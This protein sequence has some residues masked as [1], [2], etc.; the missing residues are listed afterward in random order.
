[1]NANWR[2]P[3]LTATKSLRVLPDLLSA[4][5]PS[6]SPFLIVQRQWQRFCSGCWTVRV[7]LG[8]RGPQPAPRK[9]A[10]ASAP[11]TQLAE[12][13]PVSYRTVRIS[14][15]LTC[16]LASG[17]G[18]KP[19]LFP[20][21]GDHE[22]IQKYSFQKKQKEKESRK[23][24]REENSSSQF[25]LHPVLCQYQDGLKHISQGTTGHVRRLPHGLLHSCQAEPTKELL[26]VDRCANHE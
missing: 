19:Q 8:R 20:S 14:P 15:V 17:K 16:T 12:V 7:L 4:G 5:S 1:M 13:S 25:Q 2:H 6:R 3:F 21:I 18:H 11:E 9:E 10:G 22:I 26:M 23:G 24:N